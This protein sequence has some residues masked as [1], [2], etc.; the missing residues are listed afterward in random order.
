MA[1]APAYKKLPKPSL[2]SSRGTARQFMAS[3]V[4]PEWKG[5]GT[6]IVGPLES[7]H[8]RLSG[9]S[10]SGAVRQLYANKPLRPSQ[11]GAW[12]PSSKRPLSPQ[13]CRTGCRVTGNRPAANFL[14]QAAREKKKKKTEE[15]EAKK[16]RK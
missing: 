14:L 12:T 2:L 3:R 15:E 16:E 13:R 10:Q 8:H 11:S 7:P 5:P 4:T 6:R 1:H 9:F